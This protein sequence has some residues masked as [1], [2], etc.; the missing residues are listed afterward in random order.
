MIKPYCHRY[1][2]TGLL[3]LSWVCFFGCVHQTE[4]EPE[5]AK[6]SSEL[7]AMDTLIQL[8]VYGP[9]GESALASAKKEILRLEALLDV[10]GADSEVAALNAGNGEWHNLSED[11]RL[12]LRAGIK[13]SA[14]SSGYFDLSV[15]P[16]VQA[17]GFHSRN[18]RVPE[19][20]E[21]A[22]LLPQVDYRK[23]QLQEAKVCLE[24]GMAI[25]LGGIA[26]G[27]TAQQVINQ[28][29]ARGVKSALITLGGNVQVLGAK[30]NGQLWQVGIQ[31]PLDA[32]S[33]VG[34]LSCR[35]LAIVTSGAYQRYF[36]QDN[37]RFH[38]ILDPHSGYP[39]ASGL[40]SVTVVSQDGMMA[41]AW[42][43]ALFV[44]GEEKALRFWQQEQEDFDLILITE[45]QR[46]LIS[47]DLA[48][49]FQPMAA[50]SEY[51]YYTVER[52]LLTKTI[53]DS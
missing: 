35:D 27:Y 18:Y 39:A 26:K 43:T 50:K 3:I 5:V 13:L 12:Q 7:F 44:M 14:Q 8:T 2:I 41:D 20:E 28:L 15:Y 33:L 19:A 51:R 6:F 32:E 11:L 49:Y 1:W 4:P 34:I 22:A 40:L 25:D 46:I 23:I 10:E 29:A 36:E 52:S 30:P 37:H 16:L 48:P 53:I 21:L 31:D 42:S 9:E 38:H 24:E 17:W 45:D 47:S